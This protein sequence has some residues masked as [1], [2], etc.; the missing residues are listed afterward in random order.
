M[1]ETIAQFEK[2]HRPL[3]LS[4]NNTTAK[5]RIPVR[6]SSAVL[7]GPNSEMQKI[8]FLL[9]SYVVSDY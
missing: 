9:F 7:S 8:C 2:N 3:S 4:K 1:R 6:R 5:N